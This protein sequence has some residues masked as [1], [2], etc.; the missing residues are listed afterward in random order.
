[1]SD[2]YQGLL[3]I[4]AEQITEGPGTAA[5]LAKYECTFKTDGILGSGAYSTVYKCVDRSSGEECAAKV[6]ELKEMGPDEISALH[7][8]VGIL[9]AIRHPNVISG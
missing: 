9:E 7:V 5:F 6:I 4:E 3:D 1:M 2:S 8:E